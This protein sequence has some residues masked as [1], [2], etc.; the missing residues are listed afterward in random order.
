MKM[1]SVK[2]IRCTSAAARPFIAMR[3]RSSSCPHPG[4]VGAGLEPQTPNYGLEHA[5]R[6]GSVSPWWWSPRLRFLPRFSPRAVFLSVVEKAPSRISRMQ[7]WGKGGGGEGRGR[8]K[9]VGA[10]SRATQN[11][12]TMV[13]L[14]T[15]TQDR[16]LH[17]TQPCTN[18][19][20]GS[21]TMRS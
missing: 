3:A 7:L 16:I 11:H 12:P 21:E 19:F 4:R 2:T 17:T 20:D 13:R 8:K 1:K 9:L 14:R 6:R 5:L 18:H 10:R 15:C